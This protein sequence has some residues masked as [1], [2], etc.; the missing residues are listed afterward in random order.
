MS[1]SSSRIKNGHRYLLS[2]SGSEESCVWSTEAHWYSEPYSEESKGEDTRV[3][4][5]VAG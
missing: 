1:N 4:K 2:V 3:E 5:G